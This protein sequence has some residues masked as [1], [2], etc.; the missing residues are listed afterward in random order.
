MLLKMIASNLITHRS[1]LNS[2]L[3]QIEILRILIYL[4]DKVL[5]KLRLMF[6]FSNEQSYN[7][8]KIGLT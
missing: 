7:I 6:K 5:L 2:V 4:L 1:K 3:L 8:S